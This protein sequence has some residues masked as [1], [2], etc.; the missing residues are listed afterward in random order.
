M[1]VSRQGP[2][3]WTAPFFRRRFHQ[4]LLRG[5]FLRGLCNSR[6]EKRVAWRLSPPCSPGRL[7]CFWLDK[8]SQHE[9]TCKGGLGLVLLFQR[10]PKRGP[11]QKELSF[12]MSENRRSAWAPRASDGFQLGGWVTGISCANPPKGRGVGGKESEPSEVCGGSKREQPK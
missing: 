2:N 11:T 10:T 5:F 7:G 12:L 6:L 3:S 1:D 8:G 9:G 4:G